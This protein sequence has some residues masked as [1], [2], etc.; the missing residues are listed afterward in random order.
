MTT[1]T[2]IR[3]AIVARLQSLPD[4][5]QAHPYERYANDQRKLVAHYTDSGVLCGWF[6]SRRAVARTERGIGSGRVLVTTSWQLTGYRAINDEQQSELRLDTVIDAILDAFPAQET[7]GGLILD[8]LVA[9]DQPLGE[10]GAQLLEARPVMFA[11]VLAHRAVIA[12][13]TRH[14]VVSHSKP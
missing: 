10:A 1:T 12:L 3:D 6:V 13:T 8:T 4:V 2:E 14:W 11:G 9:D 5:G 7:L